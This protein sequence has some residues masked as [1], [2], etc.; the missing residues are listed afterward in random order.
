MFSPFTVRITKSKLLSPALGAAFR[1]LHCL[2]SFII[3][4]T[5]ALLPL[6]SPHFWEMEFSWIQFR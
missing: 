2:L 6:P 4:L 3:G 5:P 1:G